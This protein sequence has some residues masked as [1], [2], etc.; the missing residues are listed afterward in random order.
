MPDKP[1][2]SSDTPTKDLVRKQFGANA[3]K[4]ATS[5]VHAKG[6]SLGRLVELLP[7]ESHWQALD[8]ASA[9]GHTAFAVAPHVASVVS[10]DL[11]PEMLKVAQAQA[12]ERGLTNVTTALADAEDLAFEDNSFDLVTCR[13]APH[14]FKSPSRFVAEMARVV[15][16]GGYVAMVDNV[17]P[18][19]AEVA[20][21]AN[22]W[23]AKR[24]PSHVRCLSVDEWLDLFT[25]SGLVVTETELLAKEMGFSWWT[26]NMAV[27]TEVQTELLAELQGSSEAIKAF[28]R[29]GPDA[30]LEPLT[31]VFYLTEAI[32][33]AQ[34]P[35]VEDAS[36]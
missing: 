14:H 36:N 24:D 20:D 30:E 23:E 21:F 17:V 3:D 25:E 28:L 18:T 4:Y 12:T 9:A 27:S 13:I 8:I 5:P 15:K 26:D 22:A 2:L 33:I 11:T 19:E 6:A 16:P 32:F 29:P 10:S 35:Q 7:L 1:D 34:K 31:A